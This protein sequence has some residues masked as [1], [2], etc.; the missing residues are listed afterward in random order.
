MK[1]VLLSLTSLLVI[2]G[3][4]PAAHAD[5]PTVPT[6]ISFTMSPD[7]VDVATTNTTVTFDLVVSN[8]AG[9]QSIKSTVTLTDSANNLLTVPITRTDSP[10]NYSL[11]TVEFKGTYNMASTLAAGVYTATATPITGLTKTGGQGFS[12]LTTISATTTSTVVGAKNALLVRS[13]GNLNYGYATFV[14][15]AYNQISGLKFVNPQYNSVAAPIWKTG[16]S[17]DLSAYY[18]LEVPS[19]ALKA[20]S[21]TPKICTV[22]GTTLSLIAVGNCQFSVY[23]DQTLDYQYKHDD[24]SINIAAGR[25]KPTYSVGSIA[26]QS[27]TTL[28]LSIQGP[29]IFGPT[30]GLVFP[31]SATPTVCYAAGTYITVISGG[32][33][34]LNYSSPATADYLASDVY[35]VAFQVTRSA[36]TISFALPATADVATH[37]LSL[38]ATSSSG[39]LVTF[40]TST[41]T[42]CAVTGNSLNLLLAGTCQVTASQI[43]TTTLAPATLVQSIVI[44]GTPAAQPVATPAPKVVKKKVVKKLVCIKNG[45]SKTVTSKKCPPGYKAKK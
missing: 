45:K 34:T 8:P 14:G 5:A 6:V 17:I 11:Q 1:K 23:T 35:P 20:K 15:P 32:T 31:V 22:N 44:T 41:P 39:Q 40:Q 26:T 12:T 43:G 36:Q 25:T 42:I 18:E 28:P 10:V 9:I 30:G 37:S 21:T 2:V 33:C 27:S 13:G 7:T 29:M 16:E 4:T 19:L 3:L 24:Q 38:S